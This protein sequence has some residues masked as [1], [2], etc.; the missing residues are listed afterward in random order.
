MHLASI[1]LQGVCVE[2]GG[3]GGKGRGGKGFCIP[4]LLW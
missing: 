3:G 2:G 1:K 4:A